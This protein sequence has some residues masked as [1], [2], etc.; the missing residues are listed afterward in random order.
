MNM[1]GLNYLLSKIGPAITWVGESVVEVVE[2]FLDGLDTIMD[3]G[4]DALD[5][6]FDFI[7]TI[8]EKAEDGIDWIAE[9]LGF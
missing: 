1:E 4:S 9:K 2:A 8:I 5:A 7:D 6:G 3:K